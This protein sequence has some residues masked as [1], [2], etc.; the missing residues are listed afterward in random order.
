ML[1]DVPDDDYDDGDGDDDEEDMTH[2]LCIVQ[3]L[4]PGTFFPS[5]TST[6]TA[7]SAFKNF[8]RV[9]LALGM[10]VGCGFGLTKKR[11]ECQIH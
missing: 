2:L 9:W 7:R 3:L 6:G 1:I 4:F 5:W 11:S 10:E 8:V